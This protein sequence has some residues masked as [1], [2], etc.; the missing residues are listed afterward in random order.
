MP[1]RRAPGVPGG[2]CVHVCALLRGKCAL[3][4]R[5]DSSCRPCLHVGWIP[6]VKEA[7]SSGASLGGAPFCNP[8]K[9]AALLCSQFGI[10]QTPQYLD[11]SLACRFP[12]CKYYSMPLLGKLPKSCPLWGLISKSL[13]SLF[14][15]ALP[16]AT[17]LHPLGLGS[18]RLG[19][20][21]APRPPAGWSSGPSL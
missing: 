15:T 9:N 7:S 6:V 1:S 20:M 13:F 14:D 4:D 2:S 16:L 18:L 3:S 21:S 12:L 5:L 19:T 8:G 10:L 17:H 11:V